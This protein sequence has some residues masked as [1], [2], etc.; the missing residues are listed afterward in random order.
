MSYADL[1]AETITRWIQDGWEWGKPIDHET[2]VNAQEGRWKLL[3]T[4]TVPVPA[5]WLGDVR[6]K[7]ILGLACGGGQQMPVLTA[8]G[9][10]CT[11]LDYTPAQLDSER[12]V[13]QREGYEIEIVR[14]DMSE[15]LPF[16]DESFDLI[17]HPVSN[18]YVR[19]VKPIF[20]EC[21]RVLKKGG[22]LLCGLDN[23]MNFITD[24]AEREI[25]HQLPFDP[26]AN[27]EQMAELEKND[28]GVQFSHTAEEQL[29]GQLEAGLRLTHIREDTNGYGRLDAMHIPSFWMTR[30]VKD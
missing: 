28:D 9:A 30:A 22:V 3:L 19:E 6:G 14:A 2:F 18:C 16:G 25:L 4:P 21:F 17:F 1:N 8:M 5:D 10:Q 24:E 29:G 7:R 12:M 26:L 20:R 27:P 15:P 13:A 11:V 23:G